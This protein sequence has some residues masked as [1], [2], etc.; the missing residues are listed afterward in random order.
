MDCCMNQRRQDMRRYAYNNGRC[1]NRGACGNHTSQEGAV[2]QAR[3]QND[4]RGFQIGMAYVPWQKWENIC[5]CCEALQRG[6][7]F[8][9]LDFPFMVG[10]CARR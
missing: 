8:S 10:R 3:M 7:I 1:Q 6:T 2:S 5:G 4:M 9:G